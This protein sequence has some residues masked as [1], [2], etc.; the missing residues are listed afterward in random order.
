MVHAC[1][2]TACR[3]VPFRM[4][5]KLPRHGHVVGPRVV[6]LG[7]RFPEKPHLNP[8]GTFFIL[9]LLLGTLKTKTRNPKS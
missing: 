6:H 4:R 8:K 7:H 3:I 9:R 1:E 5:G 2:G